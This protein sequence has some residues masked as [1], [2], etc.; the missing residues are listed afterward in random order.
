M[1]RGCLEHGQ[2]Q[3]AQGGDVADEACGQPGRAPAPEPFDGALEPGAPP[4][5]SHDDPLHDL[6]DNLFA[7]C[8]RRSGRMPQRGNLLRQLRDRV[9]LGLRQACGLRLP[10][11]RIVILQLP[12]GQQGV[13]P[14][15]GELARHQAVLGLDQAVVA[16]GPF[17]LIGGPLQALVP[18]LVEGLPLLRQV[19][20]RLQ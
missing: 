14:L 20:G 6:P 1:P 9:P 2:G 16:S 17:R 10:K 18:Q 3:G 8:H 4:F 5:A 19:R 11:A 7:L 15:F 13:L 12:L